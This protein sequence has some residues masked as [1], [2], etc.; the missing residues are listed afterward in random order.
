MLVQ[1]TRTSSDNVWHNYALC[2]WLSTVLKASHKKMLA[3]ATAQS[4]F[5]PSVQHL[6]ACCTRESN[7][8]LQGCFFFCIP[9]AALFQKC[10][11]KSNSDLFYPWA[12]FLPTTK[13]TFEEEFGLERLDSQWSGGISSIIRIWLTHHFLQ[14]CLSFI[15]TFKSPFK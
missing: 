13:R 5:V 9:T 12:E 6:K 4:R 7:L 11:L 8:L 2:G 1:M 14:S 10:I 15:L 3:E